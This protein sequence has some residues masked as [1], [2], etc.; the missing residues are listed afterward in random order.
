MVDQGIRSSVVSVM[1]LCYRLLRYPITRGRTSL[2]LSSLKSLNLKNA[3][4]GFFFLILA[5]S[6]R[7]DAQELQ[8]HL[9]FVS[10]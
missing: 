5:D 3:P 4:S 6:V 8:Q 7:V 1:P 10:V 2:P 9:L